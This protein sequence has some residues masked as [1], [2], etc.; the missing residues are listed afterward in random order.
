MSCEE[1]DDLGMWRKDFLWGINEEVDAERGQT[2]LAP[3]F[4][5]AAARFRR[6]LNCRLS[7]RV[8][9]IEGLLVSILFE[10]DVLIKLVG[11]AASVFLATSSFSSFGA[12]LSRVPLDSNL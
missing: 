12:I 11:I 9:F 6:L 2:S 1:K 8:K 3:L 4:V 10:D 5:A 7:D